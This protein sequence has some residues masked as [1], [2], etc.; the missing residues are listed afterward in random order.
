MAESSPISAP[1]ARKPFMVIPQPRASLTRRLDRDKVGCSIA[2][3]Q[4]YA[5]GPNCNVRSAE[6]GFRHLA[7]AEKS[8]RNRSKDDAVLGKGQ[9]H[10]FNAYNAPHEDLREFIK[11]AEEAG[12]ILRIKGADPQLEMGTLGEIVNHAR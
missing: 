4:P 9:P 11:R 7:M 5:R 1:K 3:A 8:E 10:R 12:E 2:S 6:P